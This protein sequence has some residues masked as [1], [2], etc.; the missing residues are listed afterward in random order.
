MAATILRMGASVLEGAL[1]GFP[2]PFWH[3]LTSSSRRANGVDR[4]DKTSTKE[5][6]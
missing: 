4:E 1:V 3:K 6:V 5:Y 2:D